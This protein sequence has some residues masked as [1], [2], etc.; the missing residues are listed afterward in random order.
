M[1]TREKTRIHKKTDALKEKWKKFK[2]NKHIA[3]N[4]I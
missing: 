4:Y 3:A 2:N 1:G